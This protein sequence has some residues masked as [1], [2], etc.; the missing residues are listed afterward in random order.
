MVESYQEIPFVPWRKFE[1]SWVWNQGEHLLVVGD[2]GQGK[3]TIQSRLLDRREFVVVFVTKTH[4][5]TISR[6]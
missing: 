3:T 5:E 4:D 1:S 2:T 6:E